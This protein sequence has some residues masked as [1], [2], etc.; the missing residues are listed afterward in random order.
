MSERSPNQPLA[1]LDK[2]AEGVATILNALSVIHGASKSI[3]SE[4]S[5]RRRDDWGFSENGVTYQVSSRKSGLLTAYLNRHSGRHP[6]K[7]GQQ[8]ATPDEPFLATHLDFSVSPGLCGFYDYRYKPEEVKVLFSRSE[9]DL[10]GKW[11]WELE[12]MARDLQD[13]NV[14]RF[15]GGQAESIQVWAGHQA[16]ERHIS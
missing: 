6:M 8:R 3:A 14:E 12:V 9:P 11:R 5:Q 10:Q 4:T 13:V 1:S 2:K 7:G 16:V 15:K